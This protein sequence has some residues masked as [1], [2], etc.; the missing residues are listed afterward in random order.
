MVRNG[1][2]WA[3]L[4]CN[5]LQMLGP[6]GEH[7]LRKKVFGPTPFGGGGG[8]FFREKRAKNVKNGQNGLEWV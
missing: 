8:T 4:T 3:L 5:L 1:Q 2:K 7:V 6:G